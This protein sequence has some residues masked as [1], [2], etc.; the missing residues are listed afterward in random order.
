MTRHGNDHTTHD[1]INQ[2]D[3]CFAVADRVQTAVDV[4]GAQFFEVFSTRPTTDAAWAARS[5]ALALI[6]A[7]RAGWWRVLSRAG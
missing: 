7:R 1:T 5:S 3:G 6:S 2:T 4:L